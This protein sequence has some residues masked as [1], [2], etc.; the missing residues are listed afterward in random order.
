MVKEKQIYANMY[1]SSGTHEGAVDVSNS[2]KVGTATAA[3]EGGAVFC[4]ITIPR[5]QV[6]FHLVRLSVRSYPM[7]SHMCLTFLSLLSGGD[8]ARNPKRR[9]NTPQR[10]VRSMT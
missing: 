9:R 7:F 6:R 5:G 4:K 8:A 2:E 1:S 10:A 3:E